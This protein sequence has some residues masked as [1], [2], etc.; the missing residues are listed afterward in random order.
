MVL[1]ACFNHLNFFDPSVR[2]AVVNVL[3]TNTEMLMSD[4]DKDPDCTM[5]DDI[6]LL[7]QDTMSQEDLEDD[8][9]APKKGL[10]T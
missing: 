10:K 6:V 8:T 5:T 9:P 7:S 2:S 1:D 3:Q 4:I